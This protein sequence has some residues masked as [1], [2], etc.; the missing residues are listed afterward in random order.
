[1]SSDINSLLIFCEGPHDVTYVGM[2]LRKLLGFKKHEV[3]FSELPYPFGSLFEST[4]SRHVAQDLSMNMAHKFFLPDS[5][6]KNDDQFVFV[7]NSGGSTQYDKVRELLSDYMP[8]FSKEAAVF[9]KADLEVATSLKYLFTYDADTHGLD[10]IAAKISTEFN[11][12][13]GRPFLSHQWEESSHSD[14][15]RN[16]GSKGVYVWGS[17][18]DE[19]TLEDVISPLFASDQAQL[20]EQAEE[21]LS[22]LFHWDVDSSDQVKSIAEKS[23]K[24]KASIALAGQRKKPGSSMAVILGQSK[25]LKDNTLKNDE[26]TKDFALFVKDLMGRSLT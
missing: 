21:S 15:G 18:P 12:I 3:I 20:M 2:V 1:M 4:V 16:Q 22:N 13:L 19:G 8:A 11:E 9:A 6:F 24:A 14:F 7:Y 23:K 17:T 5:V 26:K 10:S 25:L